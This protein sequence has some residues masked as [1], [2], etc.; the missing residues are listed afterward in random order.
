MKKNIL[1]LI[2]MMLLF[3]GCNKDE[4]SKVNND[5]EVKVQ[6]NVIDDNKVQ[7]ITDNEKEVL[8]DNSNEIIVEQ[9]EEVTATTTTTTTTATKKVT[10]KKT[11][12]KTTTSKVTTTVK[13]ETTTRKVLEETDATTTKK[14]EIVFKRP[15]D[16][17]TGLDCYESNKYRDTYIHTDYDNPI[18]PITDG[19]VI[20]IY[21]I[22]NPISKRKSKR[23]VVK[24][25]IK[26]K[27][28]YSIYFYVVNPQ[29]GIGQKV[30]VD[31]VIARTGY[32][33]DENTGFHM[34]LSNDEYGN[35]AFSPNAYIKI[36]NS[37]NPFKFTSR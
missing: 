12:K 31:T 24:Y 2:I 13:S 3:T 1:I 15:V 10:T 26:N 8:D 19:E 20:N 34:L 35:K 33:V 5:N 17:G 23:I 29:V 22:T 36:S 6:D 14:A 11:T 16:K 28:V 37:N 32:L 21:N 30:T 9:A 25:N 4:M 18:Y 27:I 7:G